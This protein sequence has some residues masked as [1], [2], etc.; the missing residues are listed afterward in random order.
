ML[1]LMQKRKQEIKLELEEIERI[2]EV[3]PVD[4]DLCCRRA[5]LLSELNEILNNEELFWLQQ[6]S[7]RWLSKGTKV[8]HIIIVL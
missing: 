4:A 6:S 3:G 5:S 7:E 8:R 2:E 1:L